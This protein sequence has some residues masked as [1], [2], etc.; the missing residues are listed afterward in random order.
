MLYV[1]I[2]HV[3]FYRYSQITENLLFLI[4]HKMNFSYQKYLY[5]LMGGVDKNTPFPAMDVVR[6]D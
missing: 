1:N 6:G 3:C 5:A 2:I 4:S